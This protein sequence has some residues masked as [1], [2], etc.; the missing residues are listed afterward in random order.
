[1][2]EVR[3]LKELKRIVRELSE[4]MKCGDEVKVKLLISPNELLVNIPRLALANNLSII[5]IEEC[6]GGYIVCIVK[7]FGRGCR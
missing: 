3:S 2:I 5:D 1:M 4:E 6:R 7:R